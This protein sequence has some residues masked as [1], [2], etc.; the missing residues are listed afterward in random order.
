M[1]TV[2]VYV[3]MIALAGIFLLVF[4]I[5]HLFHRLVA[6]T[7]WIG[8]QVTRFFSYHFVI[9]RHT[10]IGPW[11]ASSL[12]IHMLYIASNA[13][14]LCYKLENLSG[15]ASR[16][17]TLSLAN[18]APVFLGV[19]LSFLADILGVSLR[20]YQR[21]HRSCGLMASSLLFSHG[22]LAM[23]QKASFSLKD[24]PSRYAAMVCMHT[25]TTVLRCDQKG[26]SLIGDRVSRLL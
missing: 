20:T 16:A 23:S 13:A 2:A 24:W 7:T 11:T 9:D 4:F 19:H 5:A 26:Y 22:L 15:A 6:I 10:L 17:G 14:C 18:L 3:Y 12:F 25:E 1:E 8:T 21:I